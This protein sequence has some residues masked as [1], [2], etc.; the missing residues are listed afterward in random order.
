MP[1]DCPLL[2]EL[3]AWF[4]VAL[5][6]LGGAETVCRDVLLL[7]GGAATPAQVAS[8]TSADCEPV[9]DYLLVYPPNAGGRS[10]PLTPDFAEVSGLTREAL[11]ALRPSPEAAERAVVEGIATVDAALERLTGVTRPSGPERIR[12]LRMHAW[13]HELGPHVGVLARCYGSELTE[14]LARSGDCAATRPRPDVT[15]LVPAQRRHRV[16]AVA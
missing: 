3:D 14:L 16:H 6:I 11:P 5:D 7:V 15:R 1:S 12:L 4:S 13:K 8:V 10:F 2:R 9:G